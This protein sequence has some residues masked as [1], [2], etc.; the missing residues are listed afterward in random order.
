MNIY[1]SG[2]GDG[3]S[4]YRES[5]EVEDF[6]EYR[7]SI[8]DTYSRAESEGIIELISEEGPRGEELSWVPCEDKNSY[9]EASTTVEINNKRYN[10]FGCTV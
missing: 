1:D 6:S 3:F 2:R 9:T 8:L 7:K 4:F 10:L 5:Y